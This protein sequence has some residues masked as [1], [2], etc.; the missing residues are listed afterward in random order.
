VELEAP[1]VWVRLLIEVQPDGRLVVGATDDLGWNVAP[2]RTARPAFGWPQRDLP[3]SQRGEVD[4]LS[5]RWPAAL[6]EMLSRAVDR[7]PAHR[8]G[9]STPPAVP[10]L[11]ATSPSVRLVSA[12][13]VTE[14]LMRTLPADPAAPSEGQ[15]FLGDRVV[16]LEDRGAEQPVNAF[17]LPLELVAVGPRGADALNNIGSPWVRSDP[18]LQPHIAEVTWLEEPRDVVQWLADRAIDVLVI[19]AADAQSLASMMTRRARRA[20][21]TLRTVVILGQGDG[22]P[23]DAAA[24]QLPAGRSVLTVKGPPN[25]TQLAAV[26]SFLVALSHDLPLHDALVGAR[27][28]H[29]A[30]SIDLSASPASLHDLRLSAAWGVLERELAALSGTVGPGSAQ[31]LRQQLAVQPGTS[32]YD[33][34]DELVTG[35]TDAR[36]MHVDFARE[37]LGLHPLARARR[38]LAV[39]EAATHRL[40]TAGPI[41]RATDTAQPPRVVNIGVRRGDD[42]VAA[43]DADSVYVE[44]TRSLVAG[45]RYDLDVQIGAPWRHSL[46][47]DDPKD[48]QIQ[49]PDEDTGTELQIS[50]FSDDVTVVGASTQALYVP[51]AGPSAVMTFALVLPSGPRTTRVRLSVFHRDNLIQTLRLDVPITIEEV[52]HSSPILVARLEHSA[53]RDWTN[54][55][56]LG[57]RALSLTLNADGVGG[58]RLFLKRG[59]ITATLPVDATREH[60]AANEIRQIL[61]RTIDRPSDAAATVWQLAQQGQRVYHW[62]RNRLDD[63]AADAIRALRSSVDQTIQVVRADHDQA[64]PWAL[65]YD[66]SLPETVLGDDPPPVCFGRLD[67]GGPCAHGANDR[68]VCVLGF[69]GMRHR[70]E[71]L[72]ADPT[73]RDIPWRV[74]VGNPSVLVALGVEDDA[75]EALERRLPQVVEPGA[76]RTLTRQDRLLDA[77]FDPTRPGIVLVLGHNE[78]ADIFGEPTGPRIQLLTADRWLQGKG[79]SQSE[80]K[81]GRWQPPHSIVLLLSCASAAPAVTE[82]TS[83]LSA[84]QAVKAGAIVGT[85]CDVYSDL[86]VEFT[87]HIQAAMTGRAVPAPANH[88][89]GDR[90]QPQ[91]APVAACTFAQAMRVARHRIVIDDKDPRGFVFGAFGPAELTLFQE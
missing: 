80:D 53:T 50:L 42:M 64:I 87:L 26:N 52:V 58:H 81:H 78:T 90:E 63:D 22:G 24:I 84:L 12:V 77:L 66:W 85:E 56:Q 3:P 70:M 51:S 65:L 28:L 74:A 79:I 10:I 55:E 32:A 27:A 25:D 13:D 57:N 89:G 23:L 4:D 7:L 47:V 17:S 33:D 41:S 6:V 60:H 43:P 2:L 38:S 34:V 36:T 40:Q 72:L 21:H 91:L 18:Q 11:A 44:A 45:G 48:A 16:A 37:T 39:A 82:L 1:R 31:Q 67:A 35:V 83:Y 5:V 62:I 75:T 46:V 14:R 69:W 61:T 68:A 9:A 88:D 20:A 59:E 76:V 73:V 49:L 15:P 71:E 54:V 29:P 8:T 86:A 30:V 19:D